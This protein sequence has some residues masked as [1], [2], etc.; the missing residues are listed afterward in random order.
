MISAALP[1]NE[2]KRIEKLHSLK[3]LDTLAEQEYDDI[4][5]MVSR[6]CKTPQAN[7]SLIDTSRQ[8]FKASIGSTI[9]ETP[10][11]ISLCS[12][13]IL[14]DD[15]LIIEDTL[16]DERFKDNPL[17]LDG[18]K[19]RFYAGMP[20]K[21]SDG[22]VLGSLCAIDTVPRKISEDEKS[23]L[24]V[25]SRYVITLLELRY[26]SEQLQLKNQELQKQNLLK[27]KL[28]SIIAHDLRSPFTHLQAVC[29]LFDTITLSEDEKK[30]ALKE[31]S[32][33]ASSSLFLIENL[34]T[35]TTM[36]IQKS[37]IHPVSCNIHEVTQS[38]LSELNHLAVKKNN[39]ILTSAS[40][41]TVIS[42]DPNILRFVSRNLLSNAIKFTRSGTITI[43]WEI[44]E[45]NRQRQL[46]FTVE[47][48][49][50]GFDPEVTQLFSG[51]KQNS[52]RGTAGEKG[53]GLALGFCK[54]FIN[55]HKGTIS[56]KS[57]PG[58]GSTFTV[59]LPEIIQET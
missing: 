15:I 3:I 13:T 24:R 8:W 41:D 34:L 12:H 10:R 23:T 11:E 56:A 58:Q 40:G 48:T 25:L 2:S 51:K 52:K 28:I 20:L 29:E 38:V 43:A 54:D 39:A 30:Y 37:G 59:Y 27:E 31:L 19:I 50:I 42:I 1:E 6:A 18:D 4:V 9:N 46:V 36:L 26:T 32:Q 33:I 5:F 17:V 7:I 44:I 55:Q 16:Q 47:D 21:T 57:A 45:R 14:E 53:S 35:W 49:G 22:L